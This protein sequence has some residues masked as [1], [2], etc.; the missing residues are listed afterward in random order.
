M[1]SRPRL[2]ERLDFA[3]RGAGRVIVLPHGEDRLHIS[4]P[5]SLADEFRV[6]TGSSF[7]KR[8]LVWSVE[9]CFR[10]RL[11]LE[12]LQ[13]LLPP[14][15]AP[16]LEKPS[17]EL[18]ESRSGRPLR[19]HQKLLLAKARHT[20][21]YVM[22]AKMGTGKSLVAIELMEDHPDA[23]WWYIAPDVAQDSFTLELAKWGCKVRPQMMTPA[24]MRLRIERWSNLRD[25]LPIGVIVDE[26]SRFKNMEAK[27]TQA[28]FHLAKTI[29]AERNGYM[30][31][32]S[33]TPAPQDEVDW[34]SQVEIVCPGWLRE[35]S[36]HHLERRLYTF[37]QVKLA[38]RSFWKRNG[39][40]ED[41]RALFS[42]RIAPV[43]IALRQEDTDLDLPLPRYERIQCPVTDDVIQ[44]A[45]LIA[46]TATVD[47]AGKLRQLSDGFQY[48]EDG[49]TTSYP[50]PKEPK[51]AELLKKHEESGRFMVYAGFT[52]SVNKCVEVASAA[53]W[54]VLRCDGRGWE[55]RGR[56]FKDYLAALEALQ[57]CGDHEERL[58][59]VGQPGSGGF[60]L[61]CQGVPAL[62]FYSNSFS[63]E[64]REQAEARPRR[65]GMDVARGLVVYDLLHLGT[66]ELVLN[67]VQQKLDVE[68]MTLDEIR[69]ALGISKGSM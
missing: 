40:R 14:E 3:V 32:M 15:L 65:P 12:V 31:L 67:R 69:A 35:S 52:E 21:G 30:L 58:C 46:R 24:G 60:S 2:T 66:D 41:Q 5:K 18:G 37:E 53:G 36:A 45:W 33:G 39:T 20:H 62:C 1:W 49:S 43:V 7:V 10:N 56:L 64:H 54:D 27:Q 44:A 63:S 68:N 48:K 16:F 29:R 50:S 23:H 42:K 59:F 51:L 8:T 26:S 25:T 4:S 47:R 13:G 57:R 22:A 11:Q 6:M 61:N 55:Y 19:P 38:E 34:W 9:D 28:L 17:A